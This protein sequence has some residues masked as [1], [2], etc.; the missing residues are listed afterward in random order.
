MLIKRA[1]TPKKIPQEKKENEQKKNEKEII[2]KIEN[3][4]PKKENEK[5][6]KK[7]TEIMLVLKKILNQKKI[8]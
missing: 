6:Q 8:K 7:K 2:E 5:I 3:S 4:T 1:E